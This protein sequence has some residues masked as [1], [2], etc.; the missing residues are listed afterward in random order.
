MQS[1]HTLDQ[2]K[3]LY[4]KITKIVNEVDPCFYCGPED[5][6]DSY[7]NQLL[8]LIRD[9]K[10]NKEN[11]EQKLKDVFFGKATLHPAEQERLVK[12]SHLINPILLELV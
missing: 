6:Y 7:V 5:E 11:L 9:H 10:I 3:D 4:S 12:L 8:I 2:Y 1:I